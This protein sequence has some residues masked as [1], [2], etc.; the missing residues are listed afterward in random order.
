MSMKGESDAMT[1]PTAG[2]MI[3][4]TPPGRRSLFA[5]EIW[6]LKREHGTDKTSVPF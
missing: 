3:H 6:R 5:K 4:A 1:V 2:E